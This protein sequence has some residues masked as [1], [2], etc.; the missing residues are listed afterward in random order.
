[1][2][3]KYNFC[4]IITSSHYHLASVLSHSLEL[5][6]LEFKLFVLV[7]D[8]FEQITIKNNDINFIN[9]KTIIDFPYVSLMSSKYDLDFQSDNL[10]WSLKPVFL[11]YCIQTFSND[12]IFLDSDIF[13]LND[14][15][16]LFD[17]LTSQKFILSPHFR[18]LSPSTDELNF[19]KNYTEGM[20]NGGFIGAS[21]HSLDILDWWITVCLHCCIINKKLG[22]Y[23]DQ[24]YLDMIPVRFDNVHILRHKGCN[25]ASWN[26]NDCK[27]TKI[28][29]DI[30]I[31]NQF[32]IIFIHFTRDTCEQII[33]GSDNILRPLLNKYADCID[34]YN[35][36]ISFISSI[37]EVHEKKVK[38]YYKELQKKSFLKRGINS[39]VTTIKNSLSNN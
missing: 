22:Y 39:F 26:I 3:A 21:R 27:R 23:V 10:R 38:E 4:T 37:K 25:I 15:R 33:F 17:I 11:K 18:D 14:Y 13:I 24:K 20:F 9:I 35:P 36:S 30:I 34:R 8:D 6:Q 31:N 12:F 28:G 7:V 2:I 16:F 5:Q 19:N 32:P 29:N 1:M